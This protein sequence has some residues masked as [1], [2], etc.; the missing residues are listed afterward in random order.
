MTQACI[1]L[2]P[3]ICALTIVGGAQ[4]KPG[5]A[6]QAEQL[7]ASDT[8]KADIE[9][10]VLRATN[11]YRAEKGLKP[12][13]L[14]NPKLRMAARA[15]AVDLMNMGAMG[16]T[17]STGY[18]FES[19]MRA[20]HP[21]QMALPVMAE[22]AARVRK[23]GLSDTEQAQNLVMQWIKSPG[24]RRNMANRSFTAIAIGAV[25]RG[26]QVY[27][28]QIFTGPEVKTNG[29]FGNSGLQ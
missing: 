16:H 10:A 25:K 22:N 17:S 4:A 12:L 5:Y 7:A 9:T 1:G 2:L 20:L 23:E 14:A 8:V 6:Q 24:H 26:G 15:H 29:V 3:I 21:G 11:A 28:V 19:R 13:K 27:A 18:G